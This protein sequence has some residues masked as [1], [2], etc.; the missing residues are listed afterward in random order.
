MSAIGYMQMWFQI[1]IS[2]SFH[3]AH[4]HGIATRPHRGM[5]IRKCSIGVCCEVN[6]M[7]RCLWG[8]AN[9][10]HLILAHFVRAHRFA[11]S[12]PIFIFHP[13]CAECFNRD[14]A[15]NIRL[16]LIRIYVFITEC[17]NFQK[18]STT[19]TSKHRVG[20]ENINQSQTFAATH[21]VSAL[22][23]LPER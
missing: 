13:C 9:L 20:T 8:G 1:Q 12:F 6:L 15:P 18:Y 14:T 5:P 16:F 22:K 21:L 7:Q 3:R 19:K 23:S 17:L 2:Q 4:L 11:W 10:R